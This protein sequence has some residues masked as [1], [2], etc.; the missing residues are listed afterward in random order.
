MPSDGCYVCSGW[1][2]IVYARMALTVVVALAVAAGTLV[3]QRFPDRWIAF[4]PLRD[5]AASA[6]P[7]QWQ[8]IPSSAGWA[9][10]GHYVLQ[11][12]AEHAW[13]QRLGALVELFRVGSHTSLAFTTDIEFIANP[14]NDIRFNPRAVFWQEG[15]LLTLAGDDHYWQLG[16]YHRC[17]HDVDNLVIGRERSL[18][19]G[20]LMARFLVPIRHEQWSGAGVVRA[21][22]YTIRQDDRTPPTDDPSTP[23]LRRMIG[24]VGGSI[25]LQRPIIGSLL[26]IYTASWIALTAFGTQKASVPLLGAG[27][28]RTATL[29]GGIAAGI[30]ITGRTHFRI[31]IAWEYLPD[32]GI[33]P[34]PEYAH[35]VSLTIGIVDPR[36]MW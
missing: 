20:S 30:A 18:I 23:H 3:A 10:F 8:W 33:N 14:D 34:Q 32:T 36:A 4:N 19:Y 11:R 7:G 1:Y 25:H 22:A 27:P 15:L 13:L 24:S 9:D 2:T 29:G 31:G 35:L 12:D 21:D 5:S 17:K 28:I 6:L 26:G 16:Y